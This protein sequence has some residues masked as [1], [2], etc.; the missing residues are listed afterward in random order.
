MTVFIDSQAEFEFLVDVLVIGAGACGLSAALAA[1]DGG[2]QVLVLERDKVPLGTTAMSTGLI[3][4][5]GTKIQRAADIEDDVELFANDLLRKSKGT[6]DAD[7]VRA[8]CS[9]ATDTIDWL[10]DKHNVP[11]SL[12]EAGGAL[13]GHSRARLHGTP[14][15]TGEELIA[16]L[17][18]SAEGAGADVMT[19]ALVT[20]LVT[21]GKGRVTGVVIDRPDGS[22]ERVGCQTLVLATCGF[23]GNAEMVAENIPELAG[24]MAHTHPGATGDALRWGNALGAKSADLGSYQGHGNVAAGHGLLLSWLSVSEGGFQVNALGERF[25]DESRGYS[26]QAVDVGAQPDGFAWTIYDGRIDEIMSEISEYRELRTAR[27]MVQADTIE[28]LA[29]AIRVPV[30]ALTQTM[31][32]IDRFAESGEADGFGRIFIVD[33]A[34]KAPFFAAKANP[35]LFHTQGGLVVDQDARVIGMDGDPL[36]NLFAGGGAARGLSGAGAS[37]YVAGN[38]LMS[39]TTLGKLAGRAAAQQ[40]LAENSEGAL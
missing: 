14:S 16:S 30:E 26:E 4:A 24:I 37:G 9:Q 21:D 3:P 12:F 32:D 23:A 17:L 36:P 5:A 8:I 27:A 1:C 39:A 40:A 28:E 22:Q 25:S 10:S 29:A 2:A 20:G 34:L 13:P 7:F 19:S 6:A 33:K 18:S 35:A 15:R 11:F 38:G 31:V